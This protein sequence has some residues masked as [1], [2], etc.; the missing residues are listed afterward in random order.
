ML[1]VVSL[2]GEKV[3]EVGWELLGPLLEPQAYGLVCGQA[4]FHHKTFVV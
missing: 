1:H 2:T 3:L 4:M